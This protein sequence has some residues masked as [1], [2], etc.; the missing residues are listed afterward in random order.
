IS[1]VLT[2]NFPVGVFGATN[3]WFGGACAAPVVGSCD[4]GNAQNWVEQ[5]PSAPANNGSADIIFL[6]SV[7][8]NPDMN[9]PWNVHSITFDTT[10]G[11]FACAGEGNTLTIQAGG[12]ANNSLNTQT[13]GIS[14]SGSPITLGASQTWAANSSNL[15]IH[16]SS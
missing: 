7:A 10:A 4:W 5:P 6:G 12:I 11:A 14:G 13:I 2:L 1:L 8:L 16:S 9:D 15:V 3:H